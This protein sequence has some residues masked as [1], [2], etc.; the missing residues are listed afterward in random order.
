MARGGRGRISSE[1]KSNIRTK[2]KRGRLYLLNQGTREKKNCWVTEKGIQ[3]GQQKEKVNLRMG[4][5]AQ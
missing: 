5:K 4:E 1:T 2:E 3:Q